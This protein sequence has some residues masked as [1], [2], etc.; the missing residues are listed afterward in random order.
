MDR[1]ISRALT[2]VHVCII[3]GDRIL[4]KLKII[5]NTTHP[6][7][8][9]IL[10]PASFPD[11]I[12]AIAAEITIPQSTFIS[13]KVRFDELKTK[14]GLDKPLNRNISAGSVHVKIFFTVLASGLPYF[15][16]SISTSYMSPSAASA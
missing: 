11:L 12:I 16:I 9:A 6:K 10:V 15:K 4:I 5:N 8:P 2:V 7:I 1:N 13:K 3:L 14:P